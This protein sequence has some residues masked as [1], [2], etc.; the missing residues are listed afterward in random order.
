MLD[1]MER[2]TVMTDQN[3]SYWVSG[4]TYT[5]ANA[6]ASLTGGMGNRSWTYNSL[7]EVTGMTGPGMSMTY[8]YST[9]QNNG[10]ISSSVDAIT[11]ETVT[12][13]Y[14]ALKRLRS[15]SGKNWGRR[16]PTMGTGT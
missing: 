4:V 8:N 10:Q 1:A 7:R 5:P 15:A 9:T 16:T 2:P 11:G 13:Q 3:N 12:Y 6:P 14:D